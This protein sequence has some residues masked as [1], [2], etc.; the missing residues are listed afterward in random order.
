[1]VARRFELMVVL[2]GQSCALG[3]DHCIACGVFGAS[4]GKMIWGKLSSPSVQRDF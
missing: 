2:S 3:G 4:L 1:M